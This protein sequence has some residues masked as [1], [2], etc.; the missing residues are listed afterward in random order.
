MQYLLRVALDGTSLWRLDAI[1][2]KADLAH[3]AGLICASFGYKAGQDQFSVGENIF[4]AGHGGEVFNPSELSSFESVIADRSAF[5]FTHILDDGSRLAHS[6]QVMRCEEKLFCLLPSVIVGSGC[7]DFDGN[8][9]LDAMQEYADRDENLTL[10]IKNATSAMRAIGS[11][12]SD[13][14]GAIVSSG[15]PNLNFKSI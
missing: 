1:D 4:T 15:A 12:R 14:S 11:F 7:V 6:V 10:D 13:V 8:Y 9:S 2:G 5:I 3:V